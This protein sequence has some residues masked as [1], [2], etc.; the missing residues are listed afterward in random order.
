[1]NAAPTTNAT[2]SQGVRIRLFFVFDN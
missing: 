2:Q 1:M